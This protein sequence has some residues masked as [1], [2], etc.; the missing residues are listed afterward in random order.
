MQRGHSVVVIGA[1]SIG[2][3]H[4]RCF[5]ATGRANVAFVEINPELRQRVAAQYPQARAYDSMDQ[6]LESRPNVAVV[7]TPAPLHITQATQLAERG[8]HVLIEKPVSVSI[9]GVQLLIDTIQRTGVTTAVAYVYRAHPALA[10]MREAIASGRFGRVLEIVAVCGQHFP[11]YRP[12]YRQTYYAKREHGGGAIQDALTH[13]I[14]AG[15]WLAGPV[16]RLAAD[17]AHRALADVDVEDTVH[18]LTRQGE[19]LGSYSLN[20]HQAPNETTITAVCQRGTLRFELHKTRWLWMEKPE[21]EWHEET[22]GPLERDALFVRQANEF[23]DA[24]EGKRPPACS[25]ADGLQTLKVNLAI[26]RAADQGSWETL[27]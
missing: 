15:E 14:N 3:R 5:A 27:S 12:G 13:V 20:Q 7:A 22:C 21:Q 1:G 17:A 23:L 11:H 18:V 19:T 8:V 25:L 10:A 2:E 16:N 4:L 24:V 26:L 6:A 9:D